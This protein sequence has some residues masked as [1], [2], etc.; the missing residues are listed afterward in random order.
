M[1][2]L[3]VLSMVLMSFVSYGQNDKRDEKID[4]FFTS[5]GKTTS[6]TYSKLFIKNKLFDNNAGGSLGYTPSTLYFEG[7]IVKGGVGFEIYGTYDD[8]ER[9]GWGIYYITP[10]IYGFDV[11]LG[12][13][14]ISDRE[15]VKGNYHFDYLGSWTNWSSVPTKTYGYGLVSFNKDIHLY[16]GFNLQ[17]KYVNRFFNDKVNSEFGFGLSFS[18]RNRN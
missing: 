7:R 15:D 17:L 1:K 5:I 3:L 9:S 13:G 12:G 10:S 16:K 2:K 14:Q 18:N 4:K 6:K 11:S 8:I